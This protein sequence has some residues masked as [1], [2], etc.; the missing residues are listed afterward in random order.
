MSS[1]RYSFARIGIAAIALAVA[2]MHAYAID[3]ISPEAVR[4]SYILKLRPFVTMGSPSHGIQKICYYEKPGVAWTESVG[5]I[6]ERYVSK[7]PDPSGHRLSVQGFKAI[8]D[9]SACD[10]FYI[11]AEEEGSTPGIMAALDGLPVLTISAAPGFIYKGG[12]IGFVSDDNWVKMAANIK[13][14]K[15]R[16]VRVDP[17]IL[18]VMQKVENQ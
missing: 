10:I 6:I 2:P 14:I 8:R 11:P 18:E 4:A 5:Q 12:M 16:D 7:N 13:N 9:F 3:E 1:G 15:S 17:Q